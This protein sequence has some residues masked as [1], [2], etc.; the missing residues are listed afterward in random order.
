MPKAE[1]A[2]HIGY[3]YGALCGASM[4]E[5]LAQTQWTPNRCNGCGLWHDTEVCHKCAC[6]ECLETR[7]DYL[8][9]SAAANERAAASLI[10]HLPEEEQDTAIDALV[11]LGTRLFMRLYLC[12]I[13]ANDLALIQN[14]LSERKQ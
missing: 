4:L 2:P 7:A 12:D 9:E 6:P 5:T 13:S 3:T 10:A 11:K 14:W 1:Q 8:T